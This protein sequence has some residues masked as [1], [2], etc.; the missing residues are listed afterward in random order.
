[1]AGEAVSDGR[2]RRLAFKGRSAGFNGFRL[3][4]VYR[5][6]NQP[7]RP[8]GVS[9]RTGHFGAA[10]PCGPSPMFFATRLRTPQACRRAAGF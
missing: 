6:A 3:Q 5:P 10:L 9:G 2:A 8:R 4:R 7:Q 1:M